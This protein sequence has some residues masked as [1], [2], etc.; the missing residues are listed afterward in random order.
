MFAGYQTWTEEPLKQAEDD[1]LTG[2]QR[3]TE[4]KNI[5]LCSMATKFGQNRSN[6][7]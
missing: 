4:V 7:N 5:Y 2:G 1:D 3:S 6:I